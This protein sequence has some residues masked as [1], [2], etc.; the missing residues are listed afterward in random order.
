[1]AVQHE[2]ED[3]HKPW[4]HDSRKYTKQEEEQIIYN[5][6]T[7]NTPTFKQYCQE[8]HVENE[9]HILHSHPTVKLT[10][11]IKMKI[12]K[13]KQPEQQLDENTQN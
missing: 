2:K 12:L 11:P 3:R 13:N 10:R 9:Y 6:E 8:K 4:C 7:N 1:V 5:E